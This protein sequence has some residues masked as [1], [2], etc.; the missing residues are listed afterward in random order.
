MLE[1]HTGGSVI[2]IAFSPDGATLASRSGDGTVRLWE[3][4]SG[5]AGGAAG[6]YR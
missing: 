2:A 1:V 4:A 5:R 6:A 3:V